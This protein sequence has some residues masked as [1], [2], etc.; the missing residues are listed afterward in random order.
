MARQA[1]NY[2]A[3]N[4]KEL[5]VYHQKIEHKL[6]QEL[7]DAKAKHKQE[8]TRDT[9]TAVLKAVVALAAANEK[10]K[11][12]EKRLIEIRT[13]VDADG[14][15]MSG[16]SSMQSSYCMLLTSHLHPACYPTYLLLTRPRS[17]SLWSSAPT[18][19]TTRAPPPG[20][21]SSTTRRT[22]T[23]TPTPNPNS[24]PNPNPDPNHNP[25]PDPNPNPNPNPHQPQVL[26]A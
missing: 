13:F 4:Y 10:K 21:P 11:S 1:A 8:D 6:K 12:E 20:S 5:V 22:L 24:D 2:E 3:A 18:A 9:H 19:S 15:V 16:V 25:N 17:I 7:A 26:R 14:L 23:P